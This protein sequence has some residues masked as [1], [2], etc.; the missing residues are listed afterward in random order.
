MEKVDVVCG[1]VTHKERILITQRSDENNYGKWEFPGGKVKK[2]EHSFDSIKRELF[3]ELE[4]IVTPTKKLMSYNFK[5]Y[6][7][8]FISCVPKEEGHIKLKEHL[9][10]K[11]VRK[12]D[13]LLFNFLEGD[14]S[15]IKYY[16]DEA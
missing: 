5:D 4:L 12:E 2:N 9:S 13:L 3:E 10:F 14:V 6:N 8:I 15:F 7:L 1:V 11:W 16:T